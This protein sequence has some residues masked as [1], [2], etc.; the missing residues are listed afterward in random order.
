MAFAVLGQVVS[1]MVTLKG[2]SYTRALLSPFLVLQG[3]CTR[4]SCW[5][6]VPSTD[7]GFRCKRYGGTPQ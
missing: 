6:D 5:L 3:I 7:Y 1:N 4:R 2:T